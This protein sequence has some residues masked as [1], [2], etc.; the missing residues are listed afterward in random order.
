M[1]RHSLCYTVYGPTWVRSGMTELSGSTV[2][3]RKIFT[4]CSFVLPPLASIIFA[5]LRDFLHY[6]NIFQHF[7]VTILCFLI[8]FNYWARPVCMWLDLRENHSQGYIDSLIFN[9]VYTGICNVIMCTWLTNQSEELMKCIIQCPLSVT[10]WK[11]HVFRCNF[12][13]LVWT[14]FSIRI[15]LFLCRK[16]WT[17]RP[18]KAILELFV[19]GF[20]CTFNRMQYF[21]KYFVDAELL[22][23]FVKGLIW[24]F[25][26]WGVLSFGGYY[27]VLLKVK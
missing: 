15:P 22:T 1:G 12:F 3:F 23:V 25:P 6:M 10:L 2:K 24:L 27:S 16:T 14:K 26:F 18:N 11:L 9:E 21:W 17:I 13:G 20:T 5:S 4:S 7:K 8:T 19:R